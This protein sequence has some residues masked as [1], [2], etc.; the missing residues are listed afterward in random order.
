M[1]MTQFHA[2]LLADCLKPAGE[3]LNIDLN[4]AYPHG[5]YDGFTNAPYNPPADPKDAAIYNLGYTMAKAIET[6]LQT[7]EN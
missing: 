1:D 4:R 5:H 6:Y 3:A 7:L 2:N